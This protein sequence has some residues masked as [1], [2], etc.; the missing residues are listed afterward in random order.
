MHL[1]VLDDGTVKSLVPEVDGQS[2]IDLV[3]AYETAR[4]YTPAGEY[5]GIVPDYFNFGDLSQH[6][7][8]TA[9]PQ[10]PRPGGCWLLSCECGEAGCWPL[11]VK[12]TLTSQTV[13][14]SNFRQPHR[15]S[16]TYS[17]LGPFQFDRRQYET[18]VADAVR[19]LAR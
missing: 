7:L 5:G 16:W 19:A 17:G 13:T 2:L 10:W 3:A 8:G 9:S 11:E 1:R 4:G 12:V 15:P 14:W 18:A 6:Y